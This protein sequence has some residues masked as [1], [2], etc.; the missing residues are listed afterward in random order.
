MITPNMAAPIRSRARLE[1]VKIPMRNRPSGNTG[2]GA[3]RSTSTN[4]QSSATPATL[5]PMISREAHA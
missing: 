2:S 3:R 1:T 4:R 5:R